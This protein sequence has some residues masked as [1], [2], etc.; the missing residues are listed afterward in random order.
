LALEPV[1]DA[2]APSHELES[3]S[4]EPPLDADPSAPESSS[5]ELPPPSEQ[6]S[7]DG[8]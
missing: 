2:V 7:D 8:A 1:L 4:G 5:E 6:P 3:E